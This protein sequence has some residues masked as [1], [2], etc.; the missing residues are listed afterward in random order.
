M[1]IRDRYRFANLT[2]TGGESG[3][4]AGEAREAPGVESVQA[5][6]QAD[7]PLHVG[8]DKFLGR[9]QVKR[10]T[11]PRPAETDGVL[12]EKHMAGAFELRPGDAVTAVEASPGLS[13]K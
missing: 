7:L 3:R 4:L 5:R 1:C 6:V 13:S 2:V 10:G 9:V 8:V 12:V 11:Y